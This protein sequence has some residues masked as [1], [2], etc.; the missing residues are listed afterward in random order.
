MGTKI[1]TSQRNKIRPILSNL[2]LLYLKIF[3]YGHS[4][5]YIGRILELEHEQ[6]NLLNTKVKNVLIKS[7]NNVDINLDNWYN[8]IKYAFKEGLLDREEYFNTN[9]VLLIN[10]YVDLIFAE[11]FLS[12]ITDYDVKNR[13]SDLMINMLNCISIEQTSYSVIKLTNKEK[14]YIDLIYEGVQE[15]NQI[16]D[17]INLNVNRLQKLERTIFKKMKVNN[18]FNVIRKS[19]QSNVLVRED[20]NNSFLSIH[21]EAKNKSVIID[22]I[23]FDMKNDEIT[24]LQIFNIL[25]IFYNEFEFDVLLKP[26]K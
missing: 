6:V 19:F 18:W 7:I 1:D 2:E 14:T 24:K 9:V 17:L 23:R 16:A 15:K 3:T 11:C 26:T 12:K 22:K 25:I 13:I 10:K 8:L 20:Y 21:Q 5:N 4:D